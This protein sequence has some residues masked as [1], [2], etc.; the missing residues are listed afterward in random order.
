MVKYQNVLKC[1]Q[2]LQFHCEILAKR[3]RCKQNIIFVVKY[4]Q[5]VLDLDHES[6]LKIPKFDGE[7]DVFLHFAK[8]F[9]MS[10]N[11]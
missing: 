7:I 1:K 9:V 10:T 3:F 11:T 8:R 6:L 5:I 4:L 2:T